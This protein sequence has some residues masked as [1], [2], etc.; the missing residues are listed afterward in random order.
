M[1]YIELDGVIKS[2]RQLYAQIYDDHNL[3]DVLFSF[4]INLFIHF[5][6]L[7]ISDLISCLSRCWSHRLFY[8]LW[9]AHKISRQKLLVCIYLY[10]NYFPF[11][12]H[13]FHFSGCP[14]VRTIYLGP[15]QGAF[16]YVVHWIWT[17]PSSKHNRCMVN[18]G[19]YVNRG[20]MLCSIR[21]ACN[22]INPVLRYIQETL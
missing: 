18:N 17:F 5:K 20:H 12:L 3:P 10:T 22:Y 16:S 4:N 1:I 7:F 11:F 19:I 14:L 8:H 9:A 15:I 6:F 21:R 2:K 13:T